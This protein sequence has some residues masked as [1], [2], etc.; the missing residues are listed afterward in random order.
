M[1]HRLALSIVLMSIC[2]FPQ[3]T[4]SSPDADLQI[5]KTGTKFALTARW[6]GLSAVGNMEVLD[7]TKF[8]GEDVILVRAQVTKLG[9][10]LGFIVRFLRIYKESNTFDSYI[11]PDTFMVVRYE[12]YKLDDDG[13]K[14]VTEHVYFDRELNRVMSF[15]NSKTLIDNVAPDIQD[16]FSFFM[17]FLYRLNIEDLF[18]GKRFEANIYAYK[19]A[20]KIEMEVTHL[21]LIDGATTYTLEVEEL[22]EVFKYPASIRFAVTDV[23]GGLKLPTGGK[24]TIKVPVLPDITI[25]GEVREMRRAS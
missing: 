23:D 17:N 7:N 3:V 22:P 8:R 11:D 20:F 2:L 1:I 25:D 24:C 5:Y 18:V 12:T 13:S 4:L 16:T 10:F 6:W 14:K 21:T 9:G 19:E 15:G